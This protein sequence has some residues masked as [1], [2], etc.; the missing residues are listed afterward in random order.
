MLKFAK[1]LLLLPLVYASIANAEWITTTED[2]VFSDGK[3]AMMLGGLDPYSA[4]V[5]DCNSSGTS[6]SFIQISQWN[7]NMEGAESRVLVKVDSN[8]KY[9]FIGRLYQRNDK[10][11]GVRV[12]DPNLV[13]LLA[14]IKEA[15]SKVIIGLANKSNDQ[16]WNGAASAYGSTK[17]TQQFIDACKIN[18]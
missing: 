16:K 9:E 13:K 17:A 3:S 7:K 15:K 11:I 4:L 2:D 10:Y 12:E 1:A 14:E 8:N 6:L 18:I 5:F